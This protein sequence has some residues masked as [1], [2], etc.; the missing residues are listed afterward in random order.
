MLTTSPRARTL[1]LAWRP[2]ARGMPLP[3]LAAAAALAAAPTLMVVLRQGRDHRDALLIGALVLGSL[4]GYAV[5]DPANETLSA[6]PTGLARR[7]LL[8]LSVIALGVATIAFVL[9][10]VATL[11][12]DVSVDELGHRLVE[13]LAVSGLAAAVAGS[14]QRQGVTGAGHGAAVA[15]L[16]GVLLIAA[17]AH[18]FHELPSLMGEAHHGRWWWVAIVGWVVAGWTWRDPMR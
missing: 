9:V 10:L 13:L 15:A 4:A 14:A 17:L 18:R 6:S 11:R 16:L 12:T 7:R 1:A 3:T 8:R 2:A 5:D